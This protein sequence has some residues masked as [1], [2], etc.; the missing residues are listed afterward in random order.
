[1]YK[2]KDLYY[3]EGIKAHNKR[4]NRL[5]RANAWHSIRTYIYV[6]LAIL[7]LAGAMY[8]EVIK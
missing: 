2:Q 8:T 7:I 1:M 4:I 5:K 3:I 6:S